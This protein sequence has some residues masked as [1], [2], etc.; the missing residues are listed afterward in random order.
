MCIGM[1]KNFTILVQGPLNKNSMAKLDKYSR[2]CQV[3]L[4]AWT[5]DKPEL[6][7]EICNSGYRLLLNEHHVPNCCNSHNGYYQFF[8]TYNGLRIIDTEFV[9]K[10]RSDEQIDNIPFLI[11]EIEQQPNKLHTVNFI[12]V[13]DSHSKFH[14][15]D[16]LL[17][18]RTDLMTGAFAKALNVAVKSPTPTKYDSKIIGLDMDITVERLIFLSWLQTYGNEVEEE[19]DT[20]SL[21]DVNNSRAITKAHLNIIDMNNLAPFHF[22]INQ[23]NWD[24][25]NKQQIYPVQ[26]HLISSIEEL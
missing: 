7:S 19:I 8:T 9:I 10:V 3:V 14:P 2:Y 20:R 25:T 4:S 1:N 21:T 13:P 12:I 5:S 24:V 16:H 11:N 22:R 15:S 17:A 23:I 18:G 26:P 6:I